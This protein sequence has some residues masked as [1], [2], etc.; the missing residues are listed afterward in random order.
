MLPPISL[1]FKN[2]INFQ[3]GKKKPPEGQVRSGLV[4]QKVTTMTSH[5]SLFP[6]PFC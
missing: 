2:K 4:L 3:K 5:N 1:I 6:H